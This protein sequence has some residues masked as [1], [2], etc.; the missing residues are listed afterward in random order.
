[1]ATRHY[2]ILTPTEFGT[3]IV[4]RF[5][6][7][8]SFNLSTNGSWDRVAVQMLSEVVRALY[9][10]N[11]NRSL[12]AADVG[13]NLGAIAVP[14]G[15][16]LEDRGVLHAFEPQ[17]LIY[18][19]LCGN[20]AVNSLENVFCHRLAVSDQP[21]TIEIPRYRLDKV[22]NIGAYQLEHTSDTDFDG[23]VDGPPEKVD[24]VTLDSFGLDRL[25]VLKIDVEGMELK[26]LQGARQLIDRHQPV[27]L[28]EIL[29]GP[30][31]PLKD[32]FFSRGYR[33]FDYGDNKLALPRDRF[34]FDTAVPEILPGT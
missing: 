3:M 1:M 31:D 23:I 30:Q 5:D 33:L 9:R 28:C 16:A 6:A 7:A 29:K 14:L 15:R 22:V 27:V 17:R 19:M 18:Y 2:N 13:A 12:V 4:N 26:V 11:K 21:G 34:R 32:F 8:V 10:A 25:D 20:V 24:V